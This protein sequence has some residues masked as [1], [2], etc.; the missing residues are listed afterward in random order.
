MFNGRSKV[1]GDE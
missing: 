1:V